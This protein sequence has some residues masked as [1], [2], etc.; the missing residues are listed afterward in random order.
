MSN[1]PQSE[2]AESLRKA[3]MGHVLRTSL[4][5]EID[6]TLIEEKQYAIVNPAHLV[7][8]N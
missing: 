4:L 8:V 3:V 1:N 6:W 7:L 5:S 2:W